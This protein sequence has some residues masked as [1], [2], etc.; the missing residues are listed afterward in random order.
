MTWRRVVTAAWLPATLAAAWAVVTAVGTVD[1]LFLPSPAKVVAAARTMAASGEWGRAVG[2]TFGLMLP[3]FALGSLLGVGMGLAMGASTFL[4]RSLDPLLSA[5]LTTPKLSLLP[6]AML[7]L[8]IG[9]APRVALVGLA[10]LLVTALAALDAAATISPQYLEMARNYGAGRRAVLLEVMVPA[11]LPVIFTGLRLAAGRA[12]AITIAIELVS[13]DTGIGGMIWL[14]WQSFT[15]DRLFVGLFTAA[16]LGVAQHT[17]L[18]RIEAW[19]LP[20]TGSRQD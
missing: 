15:T 5:L 11:A 12:L 2:E 17:L 13:A 10:A 1:A 16:A 19:W 14:A 18:R 8:G 7:F 9:S 20:W 6:L 4:R 3:G